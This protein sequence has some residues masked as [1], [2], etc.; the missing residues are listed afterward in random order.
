MKIISLT[1]EN[2]KKIKAVH[3]CPEGHIVEITGENG[4]GKTSVLDS[5]FWSLCGTKV[6]Q[7]NPIRTGENK[8][9][10]RC[11]MGDMIVTRT[12][13]RKKGGDGYTTE[14]KIETA[15]GMQAKS[16]QAMLDAL[17]G[18][19]SMDPI[20]FLD[21]DA[22]ARFVAMQRFVPDYDFAAADK[23]NK[24]DFERR[25][26]VNRQA[27]EARIAADHIVIEAG[28]PTAA[29][30]VSALLQEIDA[31]GKSNSELSTRRARRAD[32][33][34]EVTRAFEEADRI[35]DRRLELLQRA[36]ELEIE[37]ADFRK[38]ANVMKASLDKAEA[39]PA[40]IDTSALVAK[41]QDANRLNNL[42]AARADKLKALAAARAFEDQSEALTAAMDARKAAQQ[43]A[44]ADAD[45]PVPGITFEDGAVHLNGQPFEQASD[46][47]QLRTS[48]AIA[49]ASNPKLR[50]IR[51]RDGSKLDK[52]SMK[53]L[54]EM[55][56]KADAQ[57][58]VE[59]IESGRPAAIVIVDGEVQGAA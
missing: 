45:M 23:A 32:Y 17:I 59:S 21:L 54:A 49:I 12:F 30:D 48:I 13:N 25:T 34:M 16:P 53:L 33:A 39:L 10:A 2:V 4:A 15:D 19:L 8:A 42:F 28:T 51:V 29:V 40:E 18:P 27:K 24:E 7:D 56:E 41:V 31:A 6:V 35:S 38:S 52:K 9:F 43:K 3:I 11:D 14:V 47:E 50:V 58:W 44:I 20:A 36:A 22:K 37:E 1:A 55:A 5:I 57:I 46:A 26:T